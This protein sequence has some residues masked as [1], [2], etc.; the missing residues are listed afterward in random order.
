MLCGFEVVL[1]LCVLGFCGWL[2]VCWFTCD[3]VV[4]GCCR[5]VLDFFLYSV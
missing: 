3:A 1:D 5:D 4:E 2:E